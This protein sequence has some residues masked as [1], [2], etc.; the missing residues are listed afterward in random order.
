MVVVWPAPG[1]SPIGELSPDE[2]AKVVGVVKETLLEDFLMKAG[3]IEAGG[4]ADLD[5]AL[6]GV[7][8]RGCEDAI[9]VE[10]LVEDEAL[11]DGL[12]VEQDSFPVDGH[13][14]EGGVARSRVDD[15]PAVV[16]QLEVEVVEVGAAGMPKAAAVGWDGE[17]EP[18]REVDDRALSFADDA[19]LVLQDG[20]EGEVAGAAGDGLHEVD[21]AIGEVR[22]E[23]R[24]FERRGGDGF[25][26]DGL[27]DAGGAGVEAAGVVIV[28]RLL[29]ARL[30]ATAVIAC[31]KD[32]GGV[33][34]R[35]SDACD[36]TAKGREPTPV[37]AN[38]Y[39]VD[40][41]GGVI[42]DGLKMEQYPTP[43]PVTRDPHKAAIP[44]GVQEVGV[45]QTGK[46]GLG[47][48]RD[49]DMI[50]QLPPEEAAGEATIASID[51]ELPLS[52]ETEPV[53]PH[54]L[55][56]R[57]FGTRYLRGSVVVLPHQRPPASGIE[58]RPGH[59]NRAS[60]V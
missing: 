49:E 30:G 26:P 33:L 16:T 23:T 28:G 46:L 43:C 15:G 31:S 8:G 21:G 60:R 52:I 42:V 29:S 40:P 3:A 17:R 10:A 56:T 22:G 34:S 27:P 53:P 14:A 39:P 59:L 50:G 54:E 18:G 5:V 32:D 45:A 13:G 2:I 9:R 35:R 25:E 44:D 37:A 6:E 36:V 58:Q 24:P 20:V 4:E 51:L 38:L 1:T 7:I 11:E 48:E 19:G 57:V 41:D 55:G 12:A 47:A